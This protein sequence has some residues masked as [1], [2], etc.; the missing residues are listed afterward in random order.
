MLL[1]VCEARQRKTMN[2]NID[3]SLE[4][5]VQRDNII[6]ITTKTNACPLIHICIIA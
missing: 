1:K 2:T 6:Q 3:I 5:I 4:L